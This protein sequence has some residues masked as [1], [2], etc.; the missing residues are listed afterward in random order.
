MFARSARLLSLPV[1]ALVAG[2]AGHVDNRYDVATGGRVM[3]AD[4]RAIVVVPD[5]KVLVPS[6]GADGLMPESAL[7]LSKAAEWRATYVA[8]Q[9]VPRSYGWEPRTVVCAEPQP[10]AVRAVAKEIA[11]A[12]KTGTP[13]SAGA[14]TVDAGLS[15]G[16]RDAVASLAI[17][18]PTVQ[19][20]RDALYRACE[21]IINGVLDRSH[22]QFIASRLDNVMIGL[23]AIDG[24]TDRRA[25]P[26]VAVGF[27]GGETRAA[28]DGSGKPVDLTVKPGDM[29]VEIRAQDPN[30]Q[31]Q[32]D[33]NAAAVVCVVA[34]ALLEQQGKE[35]C[36]TFA[37][38]P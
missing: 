9:P 1:M 13:A 8:G 19:L 30:Q 34:V 17:R 31:A 3:S 26:A 7:A 25:A 36:K 12:F 18:T 37:T 32:A 2:C 6:H 5:A 10:D 24:L 4:L 35:F 21:G 38:G 15:A 14:A 33:R 29:K 27:T 22:V 11:A 23:H 20:M 16:M 28:T